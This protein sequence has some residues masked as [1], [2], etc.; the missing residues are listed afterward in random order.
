MPLRAHDGD[1]L[2]PQT[3]QGWSHCLTTACAEVPA[4][5]QSRVRTGRHLSIRELG[6]LT[7]ALCPT[8]AL[9]EGVAAVSDLG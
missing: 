5:L 8:G 6:S 9:A 3:V 7:Q 1:G 2:A 4:S